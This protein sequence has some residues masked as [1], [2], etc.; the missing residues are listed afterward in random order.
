MIHPRLLSYPHENEEISK[1][2]ATL[3][4]AKTVRMSARYSMDGLAPGW[5]FQNFNPLW[6]PLVHWIRR[7]RHMTLSEFQLITSRISGL[8]AI[9]KTIVISAFIACKNMQ[10]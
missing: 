8:T 7:Q 4:Q 9:E 10:P 2:S 1:A 6:K 5:W 3:V